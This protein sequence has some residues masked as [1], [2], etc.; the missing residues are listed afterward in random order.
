MI[1]FVKTLL[2]ENTVKYLAA[3]LVLSTRFRSVK[4][5][6]ENISRHFA[7]GFA[8]YFVPSA[9]HPKSLSYPLKLSFGCGM[10]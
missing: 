3:V 2:V 7:K 8:L 9:K 6:K 4:R 10:G 1:M 5:P